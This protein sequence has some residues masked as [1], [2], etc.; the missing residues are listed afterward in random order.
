MTCSHESYTTL[1]VFCLSRRKCNWFWH[2]ATVIYHSTHIGNDETSCT[3]SSIC[4][5]IP[6][7]TKE[8][9]EW[10]SLR[11]SVIAGLGVVE[12]PSSYCRT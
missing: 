7:G 3:P 8:A 12:L 11:Y 5:I 4:I 2:V 9:K 10:M 6:T 1:F